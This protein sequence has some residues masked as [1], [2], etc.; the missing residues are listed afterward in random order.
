MIAP[1]ASNVMLP[2]I[3]TPGAPEFVKLVGVCIDNCV[4]S[5][6]LILLSINCIE[7]NVPFVAVNTW[8]ILITQFHSLFPNHEDI[9]N[10]TIPYLKTLE[11]KTIKPHLNII[12]QNSILNDNHK[13]DCYNLY[14]I[15][16]IL[17]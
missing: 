14:L 13:N 8:L 17:V 4:E 5:V 2:S 6:D 12:R 16:R 3:V 1:V 15:D 11:G 10:N 7:P 9:I